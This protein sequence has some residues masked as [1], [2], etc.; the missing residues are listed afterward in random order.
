MLEFVREL[1]LRS[2]PNKTAW[3]AALEAFLSKQ[4]F[5]IGGKD[6]VRRKLAMCL[7]W[8]TYLHIA[9][10]VRARK[11]ISDALWEDMGQ[12]TNKA[13]EESS[14]K[15]GWRDA[16]KEKAEEEEWEDAEEDPLEHLARSCPACFGID[17]KPGG[18]RSVCTVF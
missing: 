8:Y 16:R 12:G 17:M 3:A 15:D 18:D 9:V 2:P 4:G 7:K 14:E 1:H 13:G 10:E 11:V 5:L 6:N